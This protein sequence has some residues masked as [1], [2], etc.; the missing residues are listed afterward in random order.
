MNY[1][2]DTFRTVIRTMLT[3]SGLSRAELNV[4]A[5]LAG[6]VVGKLLTGKSVW[7]ALPTL[8]RLAAAAGWT[9]QRFADEIDR[10]LGLLP[11]REQGWRLP[12]I[13]LQEVM[14]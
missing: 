8:F 13:M 14:L 5:G 3:S 4:R 10:Q 6:D 9:R 2:A 12:R 7:P 1:R 11:R